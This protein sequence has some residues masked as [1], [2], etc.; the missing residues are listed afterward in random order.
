MA[1]QRALLALLLVLLAVAPLAFG[2]VQPW[3]RAALATGCL[4]AGALW[5]VWRARRG[6]TMLPWKDP[7]LLAGTVFALFGAAQAVPL[8]RALLA[9]VS[10]RALELRDR[11]EPKS[12]AVTRAGIAGGVEVAE[13]ERR[14]ASLYP[15]ATRR[16]TLWFL[17][18]LA[19]LLVTVDLAAFEPARQ[20]IIVTLAGSGVFQA[21]YGLAEY[22]SGHQHIFG[23]VKRYYT[24]VA[25]GTFINRNHYAGYLEMTLPLTIALAAM[26]IT[27]W[28]VA[29]G[30]ERG[31]RA[32]GVAVLLIVALTM[33]TALVCSRSRMGLASMTLAVVGVGL[34]LGGRRRG[35]GYAAAA[36]IV[37]GATFL[38]FSQGEAASGLLDRFALVFDE[39]RGAV[40]R[41]EIWSQ[42]AAMTRAFPLVGAGLGTFPYVF[43]A[44]RTS[45]EGTFLD[46]AHSDYLE[47]AAE[48][49]AVG[50][51]IVLAGG[52]FV[53]LLLPR[54]TGASE[55]HS[56]LGYAGLTAVAALA[57]HSLTDFN[58]AIPSNA[59]TLAVLLG[60]TLRWART[61]AM[62]LAAPA[63]GGS[64]SPWRCAVP[65]ALFA[66]AAVA[67]VVPA[68]AGGDGDA[69]RWFRSAAQ[70]SGPAIGD[71]QAFLSVHSG[72]RAPSAET[73]HY[74]ESRILRAIAAQT[75]GLRREPLASDA[76]LQMARLAIARC[77][78]AS[79]AGD[80][81][82]DCQAVW[83]AELR[84]A[85]DLAPMNNAVYG[86][87]GRLLS[88]AWPILDAAGR[89]EATPIIE[90]A[91]VLDPTDRELRANLAALGDAR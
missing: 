44:F 9:A 59:L 14:P 26:A 36:L 7:I 85:L 25:T 10:P 24:E 64:R 50:C 37:G 81:R 74:L 70:A 65:V 35:R 32:F 21:I 8:P 38:V 88:G 52:L 56:H 40:G 5:T 45:G 41:G 77:A 30:E 17:A 69:E 73:G 53:V 31:R 71:L 3:P 1:T 87:A 48:A 62:V 2:S 18:C 22:F 33:A 39:F 58:L 42:T 16:S 75:E 15:W 67:A 13:G 63:A 43:P 84:A 80:D 60:L 51:L 57:I 28:R 27:R 20:A 82:V 49:G 47:L 76:H 23:Y 54:R 6:L 86:E 11:Y 46:H 4:L 72:D 79:V 29:R 68:I 19:A 55:T 34:L 66:A 90:R 89:A 78:A 61:P 12:P 91:R 83:M